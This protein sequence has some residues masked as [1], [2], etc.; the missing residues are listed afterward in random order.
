MT[1]KVAALPARRV[2]QQSRRVVTPERQLRK[3]ITRSSKGK[4]G[5]PG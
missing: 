1:R 3:I 2:F 5:A 4:G